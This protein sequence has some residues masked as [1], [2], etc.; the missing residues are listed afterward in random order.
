LTWSL[1]RDD[2]DLVVPLPDV[3]SAV[4]VAGG[5]PEGAAVRG[6]D[7]GAQPAVAA[8]EVGDGTAGLA[9]G[10][11]GDLPQALAAQAGRPQRAARVPQAGR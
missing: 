10:V 11:E 4:L 1:E 8:L 2:E 7:D 6:A 3:A 5:D 9:G